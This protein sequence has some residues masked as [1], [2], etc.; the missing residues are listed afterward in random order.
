M[1]VASSLSINNAAGTAVNF[2]PESVSP[3]LTMFTDRTSGAALGFRR[4]AVSSKFAS[5]KSVVNRSKLTVEVPVTAIVN[6]VTTVAYTLRAS[7][8][9]VLPSA[10][11]ATDRND[12]YAFLTNA[13]ANTA[14]VRP[15]MRDLEP[16]Y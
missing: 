6:G 3:A 4:I 15:A 8:D 13:L 10:A 11:A 14:L 5:G 1:P 12:L 16:I 9:V 2:T 7:V